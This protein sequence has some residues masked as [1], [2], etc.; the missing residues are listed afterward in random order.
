MKTKFSFSRGLGRPLSVYTDEGE[1]VRHATWLELFFDLVFV[2]AIAEL[3]RH[4]HSNLTPLEVGHFAVQFLL[5]WWVW[6]AYSYYADLYDTTDTFS[7][8]A[9]IV[10]MFLVIFLSETVPG[11]LHG[12]SFTFALAIFL[13]RLFLTG[14]Y[15]RA[16]SM[17]IEAKT[18]HNYW[19]ASDALTTLVWGLSLLVP[20]PGRY[21]LWIASFVI[22]I[23]GVFVVYLG[24]NAVLV[25]VSHFPERLG[26]MTILVLGETIIAVSVGT[27]LRTTVA[28]FNPMG[29]IIAAFGF[30]ISVSAWWLY[31]RH[32]DERLI[33][34]LLRTESDDWL[35][36]R[37]RGLVYVF[38]HYFVH[39]GIVAAGVGV[40]AA[41]EA[42]IH[43]HAFG[44]GGLL[45]LCLGTA[46]FMLGSGVCHRATPSTIDSRVFRARVGMTAVLCAL[47]LVGEM[48][49]PVVLVAVI[50]LVFVAAVVFE[51]RQPGR[52]T[53]PTGVKA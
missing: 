48:F 15:L 47:V 41:I 16:R 3:A 36:A 9:M 29:V 5:V 1:P 50:S 33:D 20:P 27:D 13:L 10:A 17:D 18:F 46:A 4:L 40:G 6:L 24:F 23:A 32:F 51:E 2:V 22:S 44:L 25:Q 7:R 12:G 49:A 42:T 14:L 28:G 45:A 38:S 11:G 43:H 31:F 39:A 26:L 8:L 35:R 37:E 53:T 34:R 19:I 30:S 21:G 52:K